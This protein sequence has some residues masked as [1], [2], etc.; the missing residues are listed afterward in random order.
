MINYLSTIKDI[1]DLQKDLRLAFLPVGSLEQHGPHLP[2]GTDSIISYALARQLAAR[3]K[4]SLL[5]PFIPFSSSYEHAGFFSVSLKVSTISSIVNDVVDSLEAFNIYKCVIV[6]GHMGNHFLRNIIQELNR[7]SSRILL[8]PS[9]K[10]MDNAY[11]IAGLSTT[12]SQDMHAGEGETSLIMN[13]IPDA[14][15]L[16]S[17]QDIDCPERP[18]L[19]TLGMKAY[20]P[21]GVIGFPSLASS[22]KGADLLNALVDEVSKLVKEFIEIE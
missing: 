16:N 14:V 12:P 1:K 8:V 2:F 4:P 5:L 7:N 13:L 19:E 18:L 22:K 15:R 11:R 3:F 9:R 17:I 10:H 21:T 20:T 6:S